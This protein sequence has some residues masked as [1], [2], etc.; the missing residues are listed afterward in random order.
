MA[1]MSNEKKGR[2]IYYP[3][4][5]Q[6]VL[7]IDGQLKSLSNNGYDGWC[8]LEPHTTTKIW[9]QYVKNEIKS[10][11]IIRSSSNRPG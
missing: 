7:N 10:R 11:L 6:G 3:P 9:H 8:T 4:I 1:E 5:G 2:Y